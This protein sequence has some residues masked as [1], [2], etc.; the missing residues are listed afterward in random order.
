MPDAGVGGRILADSD[1]RQRHLVYTLC[2]LTLA[3]IFG[4]QMPKCHFAKQLLLSFLLSGCPLCYPHSNHG[5]RN[6]PLGALTP[7]ACY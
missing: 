6:D 1:A 7:I 4:M 2:S 5:A 3:A